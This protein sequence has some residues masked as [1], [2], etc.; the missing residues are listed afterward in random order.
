MISCSGGALAD[1]IE[2]RRS[3]QLPFLLD[4]KGY[5]G[6][7]ARLSTNSMELTSKTNV[8][9]SLK[10]HG[11]ICTSLFYLCRDNSRLDFSNLSQAKHL[12]Y[13]LGEACL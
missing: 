9:Y 13:F 5:R 6:V 10:L 1:P 12:F 3:L 7:R 11:C 8:Q 2:V 4:G